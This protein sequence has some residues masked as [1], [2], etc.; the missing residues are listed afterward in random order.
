VAGKHRGQVWTLAYSQDGTRLASGGND[1][2]VRVWHATAGTTVLRGHQGVVWSALFSQDGRQLAT[3]GNDGTAR[4]WLADGTG[5]PLV[6]DGFRASVEAVV[7]LAGDRYVSIHDD[8][9]VRLWHCRACG[10]IDEVLTHA[11]QRATRQLTA[12]ERQTY[13]P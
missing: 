8:G 5:E 13:L 9:T 11:A 4:V 2:I 6:L 12:E 3:S 7:P 10:P 1:G